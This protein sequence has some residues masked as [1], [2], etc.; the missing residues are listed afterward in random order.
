MLRFL[1]VLFSF[2]SDIW[3]FGGWILSGVCVCAHMCVFVCVRVCVATFW[4]SLY[5]SGCPQVCDLFLPFSTCWECCKHMPPCI[6]LAFV[7]PIKHLFHLHFEQDF[8]WLQN[9]MLI[10]FLSVIK[11]TFLL[12]SSFFPPVEKF[13][14][15]LFLL[16]DVL[17]CHLPHLWLIGT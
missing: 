17:K 5:V 16:L 1:L 8:F 14:L 2:S 7:Y 12:S 10:V 13:A 6:S 15:F 3:I 4:V 9:F 11:H